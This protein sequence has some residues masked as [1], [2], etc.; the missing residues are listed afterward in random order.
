[1]APTARLAAAIYKQGEIART[2]GNPRDAVGHF[3]RVTAVAALPAGSAIRASAMVDSA[4]AA[5]TLE[6][7]RRQHPTHPLQALVAQKL[8]LAYLELGRNSLAAAEF[9]KVA[10]ATTQPELA[11][12]ALWQAA[13]LHQKSTE[14]AAPKSPALATAI[15]AWERYLQ[16][17]PQPLEPAVDARW[18]LG[19]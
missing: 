14:K 4:A 7:F 10:A 9:E 18:H 16:A 1:M 11:R 5:R 3:A 8:A 15:K 19:H 2:A 12:G 6:G 13:E 17:H